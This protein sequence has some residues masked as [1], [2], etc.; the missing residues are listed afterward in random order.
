MPP[1]RRA[2]A[3]I[4]P[5]RLPNH[6]LNSHQRAKIV[7]KREVGLSL[8]QIAT[9]ENLPRSTIQYTLEQTTLRNNDN[10]I[11]RSGRPKERT[12]RDERAVLRLVRLYPKLSYAEVLRQAEVNFRTSTLKTILKE[13]GISKWRA[14]KRPFLTQDHANKRRVWG[15]LH[16]EWEQEQWNCIIWSDECSVERG[17]GKKREWV[18]RT[19]TQKW[20]KPM[21]ETFK[22]GKGVSIIVWAAFSGK[23]GRSELFILERDPDSK[24]GGYSANSYIA[25]LNEIIPTIWEPGLKFMQDNA[26]I[27][28]AKKTMKW[29]EEMGIPVIDW[30][31][32]SPDLNPIE[33]LWRKLKEL[34]YEVNP[35]IDYVMG[36]DEAV[37]EALG[38]ALLQAWR[39]IPQCY[40]DAVIESMKRRCEAVVRADGWHTKY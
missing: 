19:P 37:K 29:F 27:H 28:K 15:T 22:A 2:L 32:Y 17:K 18:F 40:F 20:D 16:L 13:Y 5:N 9:D 7:A 11:Q 31:P 30:P 14:A 4:T 25:L 34:V 35:A 38:E 39:L 24:K 26:P 1:Q 8:G 12:L 21:I 6:Q 23:L 36:G 10:T 3:P 33:N